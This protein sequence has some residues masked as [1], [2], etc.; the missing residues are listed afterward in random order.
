MSVTDGVELRDLFAELA[1]ELGSLDAVVNCAGI[2][3]PT[4]FTRGTEEDW[5]AILEVHLDGYRHVLEAALP[6]MSAQG[7]GRIVGV[8]SGSGW[9]PADTGAYGC[10]KRAVASLTWQLGRSTPPGVVL[11]AVSPIAMTRMVTAALGRTPPPTP[12]GGP[13]STTGGLSLGSMPEPEALGPLVAHLAGD[14]FAACRGQVVFAAG[15][16]L[17][18]VE[19]P[20]FLEVLGA[21]G[22]TP[23][24]RFLE[25]ATPAA[26]AP[27]EVDQQT[28]GG[29][30]PRFGAR[31]EDLVVASLPPAAVRSC[32]VVG[33][34]VELVA[35]VTAALEARG[36][37]CTW[38]D[39]GR[40]GTGFD[41]ASDVLTSAAGPGG[42][43][44]AV[45]VA[46][47]GSGAGALGASDWE[48]VLAE[49][50]D[51][52]S[53]ILTDAAWSRA[54][55]DHSSRTGA[56]VRL[57][58]LTDATTTGGRSRA[59]ASA[60]LARAA[61]GAT[62]GAVIAFAVGVEA[63][64]RRSTR[65]AAELAAHL[66][67]SPE[68]PPLSG[69]ELVVGPGSIGLRSHPRAS[70]SVAFEGAAPPAWLDRV[71]GE[72]VTPGGS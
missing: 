24:D 58:T 25:A 42:A 69:A 15:S 6:I 63:D 26:L 21:D 3:R 65:A 35:A 16:E 45:I 31:F 29:S 41:A 32:A 70:A 53:G 14:D 18:V 40:L 38:A 62:A 36:V 67:A 2:S 39:P 37:A 55:A 8:T 4:S 27:A 30:N 22:P 43:V 20:R 44:D 5:Q 71:L 7:H 59:Q 47:R 60:Q 10:A 49:H 72:I 12:S 61:R 64:D 51:T 50:A 23:L 11:N 33:D 13:S 48:R 28:K 56:T 46:L 66:V 1:D 34:R 52:A 19:P 68:S 57:V 17:A 54:V 9:R